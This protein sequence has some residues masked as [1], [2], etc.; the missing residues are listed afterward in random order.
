M[1]VGEEMSSR[2]GVCWGGRGQSKAGGG[3]KEGCSC[4]CGVLVNGIVIQC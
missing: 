3:R 4:G 2:Q 1:F